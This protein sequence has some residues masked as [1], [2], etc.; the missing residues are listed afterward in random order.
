MKKVILVTGGSGLV[1]T[2]LK[3]IRQDY[4][5]CELQFADTTQCDL[6]RWDQVL[7]YFKAR[8]PHAILHLA[9]HRGGIGLSSKHPATV[10]RNNVLMN[11]HV[12]EA[13][14]IFKTEKIV[15]SL[16]SGMY[17]AKAPCPMRE[18]CLH[19]GSPHESNYSYAFAKR[20]IEPSIR[21]YRSEFGLNV[22]GLVPNGIFGENDDFA[23]ESSTFIAALLRRFYENRNND[24]KIVVWGD[25]S[26]LRELTYSKDIARAFMW[27]LLHYDSAE[28]LNIGSSEEYTI[29][30]IAWMIAGAFGIDKARIV[31]DATRPNGIFRKSTD[32]SKFVRLSGFQFTPFETG[33]KNTI[34]WLQENYPVNALWQAA[35]KNA[36]DRP[37]G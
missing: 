15:M 36:L 34:H 24:S 25:G 26:P 3:S 33:L 28:I 30:E 29:R 9:A 35:Q 19:V 12:L 8:H 18:E 10:L 21:A 22:V 17:P 4:P 32:N 1:G 14:R 6:T 13:A 16:S 5:E 27:G 2:A 31:F 7:A 23:S 37:V 20:L 11:L